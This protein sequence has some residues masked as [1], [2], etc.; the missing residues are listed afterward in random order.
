MQAQGKHRSLLF[1]END[2]NITLFYTGFFAKKYTVMTAESG[3]EAID[4]VRRTD[5]IDLVILDYRLDDMSGLDVLKEIKQCRPAVP[6]ILVTAY[7]DEEVAVKAFR[8]GVKDYIKK[9]FVSRELVARIELCLSLKHADKARRKSV[10]LE[11]R[12]YSVKKPLKDIFCRHHLN[13]QKAMQFVDDNYMTRISLASVAEKACLSPHY[14]CR[15]FQKATGMPFQE[16]VTE[17]RIRKAEALLHDTSRTVTDIA[18]FVG[19]ADAN[20]L[21]R[22]FKKLT[23]LTPSQY[24]SNAALSPAQPGSQE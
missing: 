4:A 19:Y 16:Y 7:G 14:F 3:R 12:D 6:V 1:V 24:R 17:C 5:D 8:Y 2:R 10:F 20:N 22:N 11:D 15:A 9:P 21:S 13:I 18:H 23:G